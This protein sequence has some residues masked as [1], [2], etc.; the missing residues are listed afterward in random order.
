MSAA[1]RLLEKAVE[2]CFASGVADLDLAIAFDRAREAAWKV[3]PLDAKGHVPTAHPEPEKVP[4]LVG[5]CRE[6]LAA[7]KTEG[8]AA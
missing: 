2:L 5:E 4:G 8:G 1:I 3:R 7:I 6:A